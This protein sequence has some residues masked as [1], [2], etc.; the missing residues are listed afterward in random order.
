[1]GACIM[2]R[3]F[4]RQGVLLLRECMKHLH[5]GSLHCEVWMRCRWGSRPGCASPNK[6]EE[7]RLRNCTEVCHGHDTAPGFV[8]RRIKRT[9]VPFFSSLSIQIR[10][11]WASTTFLANA[12]PRP[13]PRI[14]CLAFVRPW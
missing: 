8:N 11:P 3:T 6:E 7:N 1:M 13:L 14:E 4:G 12:S 9:V 5:I 2:L 10:P